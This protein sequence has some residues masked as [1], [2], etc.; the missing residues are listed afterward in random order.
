MQ[1][2]ATLTTDFVT[3]GFATFTATGWTA[4]LPAGQSTLT[5]EIN[6][7]SDAVYEPDESIFLT[8][9][10]NSGGGIDGLNNTLLL[11]ILDD[12]SSQIVRVV[13]TGGTAL[14]GN[15]V[16]STASAGIASSTGQFPLTVRYAAANLTPLAINTAVT[17]NQLFDGGQVWLEFAFKSSGNAANA[18]VTMFSLSLG[19]TQFKCDYV[20]NTLKI[21]S[22]SNLDIPIGNN[23]DALIQIKLQSG[24]YE[25]YFNGDLV[26]GGFY[27]L[28]TATSAAAITWSNTTTTGS[29]YEVAGLSVT[30]GRYDPALGQF[31]P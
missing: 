4:T 27:A 14:I 24:Q 2:T 23:I 21:L 8:I 28:N 20:V 22:L 15:P 12:D 6:A 9:T 1:S 18:N 11:T 3:S 19:G 17:N 5:L 31:Q 26:G 29:G 16:L 25:A 10:A 30:R 7:V 13:A